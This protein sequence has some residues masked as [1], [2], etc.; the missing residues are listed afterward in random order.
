MQE[1]SQA[2]QEIG[3]VTEA[4]TSISSQTNLLALN[5]TIEAARAGAAGKGF[6]VVA[7]EIKELARQTAGATKDIKARISGMQNATRNA[8]DDIE[9][10]TAVIADINGLIA[11]IASAIEEQTTTT[12]DVAGHVAQA[13]FGVQD[14]NDRIAQTAD[15]SRSMAQDLAEVH[16]AAGEIRSGGQYVQA[17][18][19]ELSGL[20]EQLRRMV[21]Q[22]RV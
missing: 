22:F 4:I 18:A 7:S 10:I 5:A 17:S 3:K 21:N 20:A 19:A 6:A 2:A 13:S 9:K 14:A 16:R 15:V 11:G 12:R 1:L 8:T